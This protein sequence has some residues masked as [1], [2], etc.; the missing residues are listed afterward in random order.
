MTTYA[1][2]YRSGQARWLRLLVALPFILLLLVPQL[3]QAQAAEPITLRVMTFN[4]WVGGELVN[5]GQVVAAIQAAEADIVGLQEATGN[6]SR[7]AAALGGA[8]Q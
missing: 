2:L 5:F 6:T 7:L 8:Q 3:S 4:I 1:P